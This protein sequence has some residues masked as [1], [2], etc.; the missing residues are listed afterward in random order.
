MEVIISDET[1]ENAARKSG[2]SRYVLKTNNHYDTD[3]VSSDGNQVEVVDISDEHSMDDP[4]DGK[5]KR[6][7]KTWTIVGLAC[8]NMMVVAFFIVAIV[9][10]KKTNEMNR[11]YGQFSQT[12]ASDDILGSGCVV[13]QDTHSTKMEFFLQ[14]SE[15]VTTLS[16]GESAAMESAIIEGYNAAS[17]G[18]NGDAYNRFMYDCSLTDQALTEYYS[19]DGPVHTL[20]ALFTCKISCDRCTTETAFADEY[21]LPTGRRDLQSLLSASSIMSEIESRMHGKA[22]FDNIIGVSITTD[23]SNVKSMTSAEW[24]PKI[25]E[26]VSFQM[27]N[28]MAVLCWHHYLSLLT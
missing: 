11:S 26:G 20:D 17:P 9:K 3:D 8:L 25:A 12:S 1:Y 13:T 22:D 27:N 24:A 6:R 18:C 4:T 15:P 5:R 2:G 14:V 28:T 10:F 7:C 19:A 21:P 16:D 23:G